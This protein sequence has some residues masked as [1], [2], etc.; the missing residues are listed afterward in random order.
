MVV[1]PRLELGFTLL[2]LTVYKTV[3]LTIELVHNEE[4]VAL[5]IWLRPYEYDGFQ[6]TPTNA[7]APN[8]VPQ[9]YQEH[10]PRKFNLEFLSSLPRIAMS[11]RLNFSLRIKAVH[12]NPFTTAS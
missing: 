11:I 10:L 9:Q 5:T 2:G 8:T 12:F 7:F 1:D 6:A 4:G 3:A